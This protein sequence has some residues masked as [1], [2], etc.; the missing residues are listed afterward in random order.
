MC[1]KNIDRGQNRL[2]QATITSLQLCRCLK[3]YLFVLK[4]KKQSQEIQICI[5]KSKAFCSEIS[6]KKRL[7]KEKK[8]KKCSNMK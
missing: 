8:A 3:P 2:Q 7:M 6:Q 5:M 4:A 1:I